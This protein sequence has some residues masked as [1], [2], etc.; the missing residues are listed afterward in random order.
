MELMETFLSFRSRNIRFFTISTRTEPIEESLYYDYTITAFYTELAELM[1]HYNLIKDE[2][3]I[4][5]DFNFH[6]GKPDF[7]KANQYIAETTN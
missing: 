5:E 2:I 3:I 4:S 1:S 6:V 7:E